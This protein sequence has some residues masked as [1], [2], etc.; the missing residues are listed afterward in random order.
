MQG[1]YSVT[2]SSHMEIRQS[3]MIQL[4]RWRKPI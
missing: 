4:V 3:T 1:N 2:Y